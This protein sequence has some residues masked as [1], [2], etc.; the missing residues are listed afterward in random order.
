MT[1]VHA[2]RAPLLPLSQLGLRDVAGAAFAAMLG[3]FTPVGAAGAVA[4][5]AVV[6]FA[7][8]FYWYHWVG[9]VVAGACI[10]F[11][12]AAVVMLLFGGRDKLMQ[13]YPPSAQVPMG[14]G[15]VFLQARLL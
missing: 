6:G 12:S 11:C 5:A 2:L 4:Y 1:R 13:A 15:L 8:V 7:R 10:S 9:D 3:A 14:K